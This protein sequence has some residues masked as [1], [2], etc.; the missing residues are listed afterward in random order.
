MLVA[1]DVLK[2][3]FCF[4][5]E[6]RAMYRIALTMCAALMLLMPLD[7]SAEWL[8]RRAS[9]GIVPG[10]PVDLD[11]VILNDTSAPMD[12]S[13]PAK[14]PATL[15]TQ[16][17]AKTVELVVV[18][19]KKAD[20]RPLDPGQFRKYRLRLVL[21]DDVQGAVAVELVQSRTQL[22]LLAPTPATVAATPEAQ[23]TPPGART[24]ESDAV[25]R[26][27]DTTPPPAL[28]TNEPMYFVAGRRGGLTTARYQLSFKYRLFDE[29]SWLADIAPVDKLYFG[30]TQTSIWDISGDSSPFRDTSYRPSLFY[31]DPDVWSSNDGGHTIGFSAGLEHESNGRSADESRS[32]NTVYVQPSWRKFLSDSKWY[33]SVSP[34]IWAYID[35]EDNPDIDEFRG[36][37]DLNLRLG[38]VDGWLFSTNLRKGTQHMGSIQLD[39]S[40]PIRRPFFA[41]AGG[42]IHF[43]YFNGYGE[44]L[45]DYN[46]KHDSQFRI[47]VSIVR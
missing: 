33:V 21:P 8:L 26:A 46:E 27:T 2:S 4:T 1:L 18:D 12:A 28:Q 16:S 23:S 39:A 35:K 13:I 9:E 41:N 32:I 43:Q 45:L 19:A 29:R 17:G 38:R 42:Y 20:T 36:Y 37:G 5:Q 14:L 24:Q 7:A 6:K 11:L 15:T 3:G 22:V 34:K 40:Y 44:S 10:Q 25:L 30:Y 31:L 47:G